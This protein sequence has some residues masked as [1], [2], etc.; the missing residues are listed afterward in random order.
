MQGFTVVVLSILLIV[1]YS[2]TL[3]SFITEIEEQ[4]TQDYLEMKMSTIANSNSLEKSIR[5]AR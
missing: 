2:Q 5:E 4:P 3:I 1:V